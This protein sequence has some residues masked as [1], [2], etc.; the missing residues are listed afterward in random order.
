MRIG[1]C[2]AQVPFL[3]G[4]AENLT[5]ELYNELIKRGYEVEY[6]AIPFKWYPPKE[7]IKD[8]LVWRL[9]D[10]T[11]SNGEKIDL[12]ICTK[13]PSYIVKHPNKVVWLI[14]QLREAYDL[15]NTPYGLRE[16]GKEGEE[17][18][19]NIIKFDNK[20]LNECRKVFTI[21]NNVS[22]RLKKF[23]G[24]NSKTIY[25]PPKNLD[26]FYCG[27]FDDYF[28]YPSRIELKKRQ[29][30]I[31]EAMQYTRSDAKIIIVGTGPRENE[32]KSLAKKLKV[33]G[34]VKFHGYASDDELINL[35][36]NSLGAV[37][38]PIDEDYGY[39]TLEA[40]LS[41]KPVITTSD[42]GG[43]LEFVEDGKNGYV[44]EPDPV[45]IA[46][47]IDY[48]FENKEMAKNMGT[49]GYER[50]KY[51]DI[52]WDNVIEQLVG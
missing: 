11:E 37:F 20:T 12:L 31:I 14:H 45:E 2:T 28:V 6:I 16:H 30:L 36:A 34:K 39:I 27:N 22:S 24:I 23:N 43:P 47:K 32:L 42:S 41:K 29:S 25:P 40:F 33:T 38:I 18:R 44:L 17:I 3:K 52:T 10:L 21:S 4:G 48:L 5:L 15:F 35:Y 9:L 46:G 7:I 19:R 13:F 49:C 50:I 26:R 51:M 1:I 8:S